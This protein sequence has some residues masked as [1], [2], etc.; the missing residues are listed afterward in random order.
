M[1]NLFKILG[2]AVLFFILR[3][4]V[5]AGLL[6]QVFNLPEPAVESPALLLL[7]NFCNCVVFTL[8]LMP[9]VFRSTLPGK[10]LTIIL[11][12]ILIGIPIVINQIEAFFFK[13]AVDMSQKALRIYSL[14]NICAAVLFAFA[15]T[16]VFASTIG[17]DTTRTS[18]LVAKKQLFWKIPLTALVIYPFIYLLFG[19]LLFTLYTPAREFYANME[20]PDEGAVIGFQLLRGL[21]WM[22]PGILTFSHVKGTKRDIALLTGC[23]FALFMSVEILAPVDFMP[24]AV[25]MGHFVELFLSHFLWG[26]I[27]VYML[28]SRPL[29]TA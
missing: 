5:F 12:I 27:M 22:I 20:M 8:A 23:I 29:Q 16:K 14:G 3:N 19:T 25:R 18:F 17:A 26:T 28:R 15:V 4:I 7:F 21:L 1:K 11:M 6:S 2:L 10:S 13:G 24:L 9:I